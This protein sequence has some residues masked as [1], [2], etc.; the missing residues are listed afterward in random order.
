MISDSSIFQVTQLMAYIKY[1]KT[2]VQRICYDSAVDQL[3]S[4]EQRWV[5]FPVALLREE[6][7]EE[8]NPGQVIDH[9]E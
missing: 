5:L 1:E 7:D 2:F 9:V 6:G 8:G 4:K 3:G